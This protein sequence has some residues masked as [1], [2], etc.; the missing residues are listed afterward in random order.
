MTERVPVAIMG[1]GFSG[2]AV[3]VGLLRAGRSDF[4]VLERAADLGGTWRDNTYP[5]CACDVPSHL[6][7]FSFAPNP[8]WSRSFSPQPEIWA[9]LRRVA[10]DFGVLP[11]LRCGVE[12]TNA[13]WDDAAGC[14]HLDTS[15]GPLDAEVLVAAGGGLS[16]PGLPDV[17]GLETFA[18]TMFHSAGW[19]H[20][21]S[22]AGE[23]VA[24]VGTG[25]SAV[26]I[27]PA[28]APQAAHLTLFQRTPAWVLPRRD[29]AIPPARQALFR[30]V[31]WTQRAVRAA[32]YTGRE[33]LAAGLSGNTGLLTLLQRAATAHL[34]AQVPD[35]SLRAAL[36]PS[37]RLGCKRIVSS[38]DY[39][40]A[41][42]RPNVSVVTSPVVRV[43]P[44][45][46]VTADG[47]EHE[48]DTI[49]WATGFQVYD[50]A[51]AQL[52][53]GRDGRSLAAVW[54]ESMRAYLGTTVAGFP[55]L[56]L[57]T[58]PNTG[59]GHTSMV[60]MIESQARYVVDALTR[61]R[62]GGLGS[63]EVRPEVQARYNAEL[64][65][66]MA[67]T[68]W[69]TGGCHSWYLDAQGRNGTLWPGQTFTFRRRTRRFDLDRYAT[70]PAG[71]TVAAA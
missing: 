55:N 31:P 42:T 7:S 9:Y 33:V 43:T 52:V 51:S 71:S 39:Y 14:W 60:Y 44:A 59:Q 32:Q 6:Y 16:E 57:M 63:V 54:S 58:G 26:Q 47:T 18:G 66:R 69:V 19:R 12:V 29:H 68:V 23:R 22:L 38:D 25:A 11:H 45:G 46:V 62:A 67:R 37:Y 1:A 30:R 17:A 27:V 5:G 50:T 36:T 65:R 15:A 10:R 35:A 20:D 64:D 70:R 13:C 40:P 21:H 34:R 53:R 61:M 4:V 49:V 48:L 56:F 2:L 41:L 3:A 8:S 28:V 24:V